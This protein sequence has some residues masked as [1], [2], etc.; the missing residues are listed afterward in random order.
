MTKNI[1]ITGGLG[2]IGSNFILY[3]IENYPM[4]K[5]YNFDSITYAADERVLKEIEHLPNYQFIKG[6]IRNKEAIH[7]AFKEYRITDVIH[8]AAESHVD[9]SIENPNIFAET[10]IMGTLNL[11]DVAKENWMD[12]PFFYKEG[13]RDSRF[14]HISTDE[15]YGTL[16]KEGHFTE[17]SP[18][19]PNSPYSASKASSDML[20]RSFYHTYGM[21]VVTTNCS[22]NY[23]PRQHS[24]KLIPKLIR[25]A[26]NGETLPIYGTGENIRDWLFVQDHCS[27]IDKVFRDGKNGETYLI[28]GNNEKSNLQIVHSICGYLDQVIPRNYKYSSLITFVEDRH[29]HDFRYAIDAKKLKNELNWTPSVTFEMG[30]KVTIDWYIEKYNEG[31]KSNGK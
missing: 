28:G 21:N 13:Y 26:L 24:E 30:L 15:V 18:Y 11:L 12:A 6:D 22:N 27:A 31:D 9:N 3:M 5:L 25:R 14:H 8:F 1:L 29:G 10:N 4:Y 2:F 16:G 19:A 23:G 17:D 20:V 7:K